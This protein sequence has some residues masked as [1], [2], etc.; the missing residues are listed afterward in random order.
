MTKSDRNAPIIPFKKNILT[1]GSVISAGNNVENESKKPDTN[2]HSFEIFPAKWK[3]WSKNIIYMSCPRADY[4]VQLGE[5]SI[6]TKLF[7]GNCFHI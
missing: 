3:L 2:H 5:T 7:K 1:T 6:R 4:L